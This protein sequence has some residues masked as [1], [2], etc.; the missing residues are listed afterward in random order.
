MNWKLE[1]RNILPLHELISCYKDIPRK[2]EIEMLYIGL[3]IKGFTESKKDG[4]WKLH[5]D[6]QVFKNQNYQYQ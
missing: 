1:Y 4:W 6:N 5:R 2:T 3:K